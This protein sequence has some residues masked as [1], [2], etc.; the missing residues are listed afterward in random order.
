MMRKALRLRERG[1]RS[2]K[3]LLPS[4]DTVNN[5]MKKEC[6]SKTIILAKKS[7]RK[8]KQL[9]IQFLA[10][11]KAAKANKMLHYFI[12]KQIDSIRRIIN[13]NTIQLSDT[14]KMLNENR[15]QLSLRLRRLETMQFLRDQEKELKILKSKK[16]KATFKL[17][18]QVMLMFGESNM[19]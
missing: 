5:R 13:R 12:I 3:K 19:K 15:R 7:M 4:K 17:K 14:I 2:L 8:F 6:L 1:Y 11:A 10:E 9:E 16:K 18:K